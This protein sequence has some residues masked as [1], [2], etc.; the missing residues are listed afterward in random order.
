MTFVGTAE[1]ISPE[2]IADK[3]AEFGTDIWA[4]GVMLYL[5]YAGQTPF[6]GKNDEETLDNIRKLNFSWEIV[7]KHE[8]DADAC[9]NSLRFT[10]R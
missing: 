9:S 1:Y 2:V 6:K 4:F 10:Q 8:C 5:F 3:Q 7:K